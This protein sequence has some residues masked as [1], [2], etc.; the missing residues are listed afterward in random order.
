M[1]ISIGFI[2]CIL[3]AL[4]TIVQTTRVLSTSEQNRVVFAMDLRPNLNPNPSM[5]NVHQ[6]FEVRLIS[7]YSD[8]TPTIDL[9]TYANFSA[10]QSMHSASSVQL[11]GH[12]SN[13]PAMIEI[14]ESKVLWKDWMVKIGLGN[15]IP[16][17]YDPAGDPS[18]LPYPVVL[19]TN[20]HFGRGV[21][22]MHNEKDYRRMTQNL[23]T[24]NTPYLLEEA[25]TGSG[26]SEFSLWGSAHR[27][28]LLSVRCMKEEYSADD[29][30]SAYRDSTVN[31]P[32]GLGKD[33]AVPFISGFLQKKISKKAM[34]CGQDLVEVM[35]QMMR[36]ANFTGPW[37]THFK[38][39]NAKQIKLHEV[40]ARYCGSL[41]GTDVLFLSTYVPIAFAIAD[42]NPSAK[43]NY[44][45]YQGPN[46]HT[47]RR[48]RE[49]EKRI[50]RSG[51]GVHQQ[52]WQTV[53]HF[54]PN[55][56]LDEFTTHTSRKQ[57]R[58]TAR[59]ILGVPNTTIT[60]A[61]HGLPLTA[62]LFDVLDITSEASLTEDIDLLALPDPAELTP[63]VE[64]CA[65]PKHFS[66]MLNRL[67]LLKL[68]N[69][70]LQWMAWMRSIGLSDY[71]PTA[72]DA[73]S[74]PASAYPMSLLTATKMANSSMRTPTSLTSSKEYAVQDVTALNQLIAQVR[75]DSQ[76]AGIVLET[77]RS[78]AVGVYGSVFR[79]SLIS[80]RCVKAVSTPSSVDTSSGQR[81]QLSLVACSTELVTVMN[82]MFNATGGYTGPFCAELKLGGGSGMRP[83]LSSFRAG[84][85]SA[86]VHSDALFIATFVPLSVAV[87]RE[88]SVSGIVA[89]QEMNSLK[90]RKLFLQVLEADHAVLQTG[91][92]TTSSKKVVHFDPKER[93]KSLGYEKIEG[94]QKLVL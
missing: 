35:R 48:L 27:G 90:G 93:V 83:K 4:T 22:V 82:R 13:D 66:N 29:F 11:P 91:A 12:V 51:G 77:L 53:R 25:L 61:L 79:G 31:K 6:L 68:L 78:V 59:I 20:V 17:S 75:G 44:P 16:V 9:L 26:L 57:A 60:D 28:E 50:L 67:P 56:L 76:L 73:G 58:A 41:S 38:L 36:A 88:T 34:P 54:N 89:D 37:C 63:L 39:N 8:I 14:F 47:F 49:Q 69:H 84:L 92:G 15:Y 74:A 40:N 30:K 62:T 24:H 80:M 19:K 2:C 81:P 43:I 65:H 46:R 3:N 72:L 23:T 32:A 33:S 55:L 1:I 71:L 18:K 70:P 52:A 64:G 10:M 86:V 7:H 5:L 42:A 21:F 94:L 85:C 87:H 45:L